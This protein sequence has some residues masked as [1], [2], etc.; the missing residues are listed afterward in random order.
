MAHVTTHCVDTFSHHPFNLRNLFIID[1]IVYEHATVKRYVAFGKISEHIFFD[2]ISPRQRAYN[3]PK[4][5]LVIF[6]ESIVLIT[7]SNR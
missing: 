1:V 2:G 5:L 3:L 7:E 6:V 4:S